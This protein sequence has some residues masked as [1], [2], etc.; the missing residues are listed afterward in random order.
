MPQRGRFACFAAKASIASGAALLRSLRDI[1]GEEVA[2]RGEAVDCSQTDMVGV[3]VQGPSQPV[4]LIASS[5]A[6]PGRRFGTG[7]EMLA[8]ALVP[9]DR[10]IEALLPCF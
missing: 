6:R 9:H 4:S 10:D 3:D 1:E 7:Q 2:V 5:A 8:V